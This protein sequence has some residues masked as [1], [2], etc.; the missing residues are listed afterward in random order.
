MT[1]GSLFSG[2]GGLELGLESCGV[3][4]VIWQAESDPYARAVLAKHWPEVRRYNDVRE[5]DETAERP[6]VICGGFPCQ[7]ISNAGKRVGI[8]GKRSGLWAEFARVICVL[9]PRFVFVENVAA[10]A[11]R[12]LNVVLGD[13][14]KMGLNAEWGVL[15]ACAADATHTRARMFILAYS[16]SDGLEARERESDGQRR[17]TQVP[18]KPLWADDK[19]S[20]WWLSEPSVDRVAHG[21]PRPVDRT[22][23][24]GNAVVPQQAAL[25]WRTLIARAVQ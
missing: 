10:L 5:I 11:N 25:A 13:L 18:D 14:A 17:T 24:L 22:R 16:D 3:G 20:G 1:I 7:D 12:G 23:C 6:D 21:L 19:P 4:P 8:S 9:R 2:I 15:T